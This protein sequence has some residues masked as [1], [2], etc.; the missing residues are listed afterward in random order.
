M[1]LLNNGGAKGLGISPVGLGLQF[2]NY[3]KKTL[4][5]LVAIKGKTFMLYKFIRVNAKRILRPAFT[6]LLHRWPSNIQRNIHH[7]I[8]NVYSRRHLTVC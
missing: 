1:I 4:S 2:R 8:L 5:E 6:L 7:V 3:T